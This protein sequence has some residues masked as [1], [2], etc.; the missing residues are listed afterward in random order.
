MRKIMGSCGISMALV[1]LA[2]TGTPA[3][4][5]TASERES[6]ADHRNV[7]QSGA[8]QI[9]VT[10]QYRE[11][12]LED[13]PLAIQAF[14]GEQLEEAGVSSLSELI[15][16]IPGASEGRGNAA[17]IQSYQIRGVSSFYGDSTIGY[18]LDEAAYV[19]PNRNYAPVA[20]TFDVERVEVRS[21]G[22]PVTRRKAATLSRRAFLASSIR[23]SSRIRIKLLAKPVDEMTIKLAY[24]RNIAADDWG[25]NLD[26]ANLNRFPISPVRGFARQVYDMYTGFLSYDFGPV[27][28]ESSTGFRRSPTLI[29]S[30]RYAQLWRLVFAVG[31][32]GCS[33]FRHCDGGADQNQRRSIDSNGFRREFE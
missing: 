15:D 22:L 2:V 30:G 17:G 1:A 10:A 25:R 23:T 26:N 24:H 11:Q 14:G 27:T 18:Y 7:E 5:Q 29:A 6:D 12:L 33:S 3:A 32:Y 28:I 20:R 4:A 31:R 16:F 9:V 13:V 21:A 19:I 8:P